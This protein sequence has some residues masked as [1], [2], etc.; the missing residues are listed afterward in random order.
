MLIEKFLSEREGAVKCGGVVRRY[1][2]MNKALRQEV[3]F[4]ARSPPCV[5]SGRK[6]ERMVADTSRFLELDIP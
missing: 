1:Y 4:T 3:A 2:S 6:K 5:I